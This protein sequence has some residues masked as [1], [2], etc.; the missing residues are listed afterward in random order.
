[1][2]SHRKARAGGDVYVVALGN[3]TIPGGVFYDAFTAQ[4]TGWKTFTIDTFATPNL[5][6]FTLEHLRALPP[7]LPES[8]EIFQIS[9]DPI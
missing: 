6:G 2:G 3:P 7:D 5:Q 4:R 9:R 1:V 8:A